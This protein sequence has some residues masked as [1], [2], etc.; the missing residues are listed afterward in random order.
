MAYL[1]MVTPDNHNKFYQMDEMNGGKFRVTY[2]R[3]GAAGMKKVYP[4]SQWDTVYRQKIRKGY[5]DVSHLHRTAPSGYKPIED[6]AIREFFKQIESYS[7][8][9]LQKNYSVDYNAVTQEMIRE[10]ES[11]LHA[12]E[13]AGSTTR[14][15][16]LLSQLFVVIP[17]K[18]STVQDYL[19]GSLND[20][21]DV[22]DREWELLDV[23]RARVTDGTSGGST[24]T[25]VLDAY[26]ISITPITGK[27]EYQIKRKLT[28]ESSPLFKTAYRVRN[29]RTDDRF[30][31]YM[32][33][34]GYT[35]KDIHYLYHGSRN[36]NW[37]GLMKSGP[38]LHPKGVV[39]NGKMF[40]NGI[41]FANRAKK[42]IGYTSYGN[43]VWTGGGSNTGYIA[44]YKVLYKN[45][46]DLYTAAT[47]TTARSIAPHDAVFAH[48]GVSLLNDEI[49][50][51]NE[52]QATLQYVI[53]LG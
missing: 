11:K 42:S 37:L 15:N 13:K 43:A 26:G 29:K 45:Q 12:L 30:Y 35:E 23:M 28:A 44:V 7:S 27:E 1:L 49:I 32:A 39:M 34:N 40:G 52:A 6:P 46:K 8:Q 4:M 2:G 36:Q 19:C 16:D 20:L 24:D 3:V 33:D 25:T 31:K 48:K 9:A 41:Y 5:V 47:G 53:Q 14:A 10:A 17:R 22:L 18:M 38:L 51:Y 50:I 21:P